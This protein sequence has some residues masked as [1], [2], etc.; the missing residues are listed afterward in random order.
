MQGRVF[1]YP[2]FITWF[3][4]V[5]G[6]ICIASFGELGKKFPLFA[7]MPRIEFNIKIAK[8]IAP[9]T[10][11]FVGMLVFNNLCLNYVEVWFYQVARSLS[12]L[13]SVIFTYFILHTPT[14]PSALSTCAIVVL[15]FLM[16]SMGHG[17][18]NNEEKK[19][20][21]LMGIFFGLL[22]SVFVALYG[23]VVKRKLPAV[24][25][26]EWLLLNYNTI[27]SVIF[28][29]PLIFAAGE[30]GVLSESEVLSPSFWLA[31]TITGVVSFLIALAI[32]MQIKATSPLTN[33]ISGTAK[34]C[35]QT[36]LAIII[37]HNSVS[38]MEGLGIFLVIGGSFLYSLVRYT[39][40]KAAKRTLPR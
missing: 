13:F 4:Q 19:G 8:T 2:V 6:V 15:G 16:G 18:S 9:L 32:F 11:V 23:I 7:F 10:L 27:L 37:W 21:K 29:F 1:P 34:A 12:I 22:S 36:L 39:E 33:T 35:V 25:N 3:Q 31:M 20:G 38:F 5:M 14:S 40:G 30:A 28:L 26:D 24:N 17:N